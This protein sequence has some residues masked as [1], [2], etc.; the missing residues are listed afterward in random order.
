MKPYFHIVLLLFAVSCTS[1]T[2]TQ[3]GQVSD[4]LVA[5]GSTP[6]QENPIEVDVA[7]DSD[8]TELVDETEAPVDSTWLREFA[9]RPLGMNPYEYLKSVLEGKN[10]NFEDSIVSGETDIVFGNSIITILITEA[11]GNVVCS[12]DID[13]PEIP[14]MMD[15]EIGMPREDFLTMAGISTS[16]LTK[17]LDNKEY[18]EFNLYYEESTSTRTTFWFNEK[19]LIRVQYV[20]SPCIMYD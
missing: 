18:V 15:V 11:Y 10:V 2:N 14:M 17:N 3:E 5:E 1:S 12:A 19:S 7:Q 20:F 6:S 16:L 9:G 4:S 8:E 13:T